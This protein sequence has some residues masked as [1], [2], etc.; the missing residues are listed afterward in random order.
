MGKTEV[1]RQA[2]FDIY[3]KQLHGIVSNKLIE[4]DLK[5]DKTYICPICLEQFSEKDLDTSLENFLTL[6]DAPPKSLG[7]KANTLTC[8]KCN[9]E[10]GYKVDF[11]LTQKLYEMGVQ[12]FNPNT[13]SKVTITHKGITVNGIIEIDEQRNIKMIHSEKANN[14]EFL[15]DYIISTDKDDIVELSFPKTRVDFQK[16]EV[17]LLKSAYILAFQHFGYSLILNNSYNIVREQILYPDKKIYPIGFWS[18][19]SIINR[20]NSGFYLIT[21][22]GYAGFHVFF[23]LES[24]S[25]ERGYAVYLPISDK[26]TVNVIA[27]LK[28]VEAG[29]EFSYKSYNNIDFITNMENQSEIIN[30]LKE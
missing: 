27:K 15:N 12:S 24:D 19:Q 20:S 8:E 21:K 4:I 28:E 3:S 2:I 6:E 25:E 29:E 18:K 11:H 10:A 5:Y 13:T 17:A 1:K 16:F 7:G 23:V 14:P 22:E 30:L 26:H 9:N